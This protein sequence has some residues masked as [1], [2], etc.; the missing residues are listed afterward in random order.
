MMERMFAMPRIRKAMLAAIAAAAIPATAAAQGGRIAGTVTDSSGGVVAGA[1]VTVIGPGA[2]A[3]TDGDGRYSIAGVEPGTYQLRAQSIGLH[4]VTIR[5]ISV[6]AGETATA[7]FILARGSLRL[8]GI[9]VSASRRTEKVTDAPATITRI[10][11]TEIENAAG[12]SF[13]PA[14]KA[15]KGL[16]FIQTGIMSTAV[17]ARGFNTAFNNR[18]LQLEDGRIATLPESGLPTGTLT[19]IPKVDIASIEVLVGPGSALYGPDASSGVLT[20][21]T[22]DP[23]AYPGTTIE[24]TGGNRSFYDVQ[25]RHAG[26]FGAG[27]W[28][29]KIS[30]EHEAANDWSNHNVYAPVSG[31]T[32]SPEIGANFNSSVT[33]GEGAIVHYFP[34]EGGRLEL[35]AGASRSNTIGLTNLGRNQIVGWKYGNAQLRYTNRNWFAQIYRVESRSGGTY[36]LNGFAQNRIRFPSL[37]D[38]SVKKLSSFPDEAHMS[39]AEI[40]NTFTAAVLDG[41]HFTWGGQIRYDDVSSKRRWLLDRKTGKNVTIMEKGVYAQAEAQMTGWLRLIGAARY[42][43]HDLYKPQWSPKAGI[44]VTPVTDQTLR[45]TYN[46]AFKSPSI[47]QTSFFY[48]DFQPYVG[49]F[50]NRDGFIIKNGSGTVVNTIAPIEPELND[51]WE[52]GYKGILGG[53]LYVDATGYYSRFDHFQSPLVVIANFAT[54]ASLG[55]PTYAFDAK[56]GAAITGA[57]GGPQIPLTYFN[58]GRAKV[59]GA[60]I[61]IRYL[62]APAI[63]LYGTTSLQKVDRIERKPKDPLEA[64]AFNSPT[65]KFTIGM[66]FAELVSH[67]LSAGWMVRYVNGYDFLSGVNNGHVPTFGTLDLSV[68][69]TL[70][71]IGSRINLGVQNLLACRAGVTLPNGYI[72]SGR[73]EIYTP[74]RKCGFGVKHVEMLNSPEIGTTVF[75]GVRFQR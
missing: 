34:G 25:G 72:A 16:D 30:A 46:R 51:T 68:G 13:A 5:G 42:D 4:P 73:R 43:K 48:P 64:T 36:Q 18:I 59:H 12:N 24:V 1:T 44:L 21:T 45:V 61:G 7:D 63:D 75:L 62:I 60:D 32:P 20:L 19:T 50:G 33:R 37:S 66:D 10:D 55:G 15:A 41:L 74:G 35:N 40:Q 67:E 71:E 65:S 2:R 38:D 52:L 14:L 54:P 39:A 47:L 23:R 26:V 57:T 6:R 27:R 31:T 3:T 58:V 53:K 8:A 56:T 69:Y 9:V 29:Y 49:V 22:K 70:P 11:A 17:N 28:G